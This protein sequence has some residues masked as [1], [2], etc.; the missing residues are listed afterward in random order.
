M[1]SLSGKKGLA[2][3]VEDSKSKQDLKNKVAATTQSSTKG[4]E[5]TVPAP[6]VVSE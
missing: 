2:A 6:D 4:S 5:T 1:I 3:A